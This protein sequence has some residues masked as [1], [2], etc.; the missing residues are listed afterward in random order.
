M[1]FMAKDKFKNAVRFKLVQKSVRD[2]TGQEPRDIV[3]DGRAV[4]ATPVTG[5]EARTFAPMN[6]AARELLV[7]SSYAHGRWLMHLLTSLE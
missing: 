7:S 1:G 4:F 2:Q 6:K 3:E 5:E